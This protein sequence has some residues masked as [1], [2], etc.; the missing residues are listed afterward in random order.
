MFVIMGTWRTGR[1]LHFERVSRESM[2]LGLLLDR[3]DKTAI[4]VAGPA[5]FL[6]ARNDVVP[7]ALLHNLKHNKVLH[8]RILLVHVETRDTPFVA[9]GQR[10]E[11]EKLGKGFFAMQINYGF[12]EMPDV[13]KALGEA[14]AFGL[15]LDMD[16]TT[17]F[18]GHEKLVAAP[19][20]AL[21]GWR[22]K[23]YVRLSAN[24]LS[25][26]DFYHLPPNRVVELGSQISI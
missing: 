6:S 7:G 8:E 26:A 12:F 19:H 5:V 9:P 25:P 2:P 1:R 21:G 20:P 4:R 24:A 16:T 15:A 22:T 17:F 18:V 14:R 3:V 23:L 10:I 13:P 11:V